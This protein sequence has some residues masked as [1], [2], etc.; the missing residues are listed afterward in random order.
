MKTEDAVITQKSVSFVDLHMTLLQ[1]RS[2]V[3]KIWLKTI[4]TKQ[5]QQQ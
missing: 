3:W 2:D 1:Q 4:T 5:Q